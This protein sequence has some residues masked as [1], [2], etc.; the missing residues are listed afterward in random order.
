[1]RYRPL[2]WAGVIPCLLAGVTD[3][4]AQAA[5]IRIVDDADREVVL[6][7]S[8]RRIVSL[9]P[10]ATEIIFDLGEGA[11]V[12]GR[13]RYDDYPP[14][15]LSVPDVGD[16]IRPSVE[17]VLRRKPDLVILVGGSDNASGVR[18]MQR[19][20]VPFI[21]VRFNT[22]DDL[23]SNVRRLGR[24]LGREEAAEELW[25]EVADDLQAVR[26]AVAGLPRPSVYYDVGYPPAFTIGSGSY[27]DEL[28]SIA[29]GRNV[30]GDLP[31]PSPRVSLEAI[32]AR[33]PVLI[34][35][36]V[37]ALDSA[38]SVG[39]GERPGWSNLRAVRDSAVVTVPSAVVHRLGP[40]IGMAARLLAVAIHPELCG[41]LAP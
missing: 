37:G 35:Y 22:L 7:G 18:E 28:I 2:L 20:D 3:L 39:P 8:P 25:G 16:A 1:L 9:V 6:L 5:P 36:P 40:R 13:S 38:R 4:A 12:V 10:V 11:R 31:A 21:V 33:D 15:V 29:G 26:E 24:I 34:I 17:T 23:R 30:F 14:G 27:L 32:I 19:L 41:E